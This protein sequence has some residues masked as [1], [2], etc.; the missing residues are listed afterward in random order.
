MRRSLYMTASPTRKSRFWSIDAR[1]QAAS[2]T[3]AVVICED[4]SVRMGNRTSV[5]A[6]DVFM[7][8]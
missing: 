2:L 6:M 8:A 7:G 5:T 3:L 4:H 1:I